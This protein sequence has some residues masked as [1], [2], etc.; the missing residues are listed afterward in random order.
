RGHAGGPGCPLPQ[1]GR[2]PRGAPRPP[3]RLDNSSLAVAQDTCAT[4][5]R[6]VTATARPTTQ[7]TTV[8]FSAMNDGLV[9]D[10]HPQ[11][12]DPLLVAAFEGWNDAG[13]AATAAAEWL[14]QRSNGE[15][16]ASVDPDEHVDYQSR[17]PRV[18][19]VNGVTR[20]IN[21]PAHEYF[22]GS[23]G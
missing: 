3:R 14:V 23:F 2:E 12:R 7:E 9:W 6:S 18:E 11:L 22:A 1:G 19:L 10:R 20:A 15:R 8:S 13:D 16:F 5:A 21:W 17:R 4:D